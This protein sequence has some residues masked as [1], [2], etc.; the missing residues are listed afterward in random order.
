M[1]EKKEATWSDV[2][3]DLWY[4]EVVFM[5]LKNKQGVPDREHC[6][7][8]WAA[9]FGPAQTYYKMMVEKSWREDSDDGSTNEPASPQ[10]SR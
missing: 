1:T 7:W 4:N 2:D 10:Q 6:Q 9:G 5:F 8:H 3:F